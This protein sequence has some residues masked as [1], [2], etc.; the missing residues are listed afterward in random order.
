[1][2]IFFKQADRKELPVERLSIAVL[3]PIIRTIF[4][5]DEPVAVRIGR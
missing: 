2:S 4:H 1:M 5:S 3:E